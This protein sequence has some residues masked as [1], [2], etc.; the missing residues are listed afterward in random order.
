MYG[1]QETISDSHVYFKSSTPLSA[2]LTLF[3][4]S[5]SHLAKLVS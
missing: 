3:F 2:I 5:K 4:D 1:T